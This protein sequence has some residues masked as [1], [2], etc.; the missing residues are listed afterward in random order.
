M[1][2]ILEYRLVVLDCNANMVE[3]PVMGSGMH[4]E[5]LDD[6]ARK[7]RYEYSGIDD[8]VSKNNAIFANAGNGYLIVH[9]PE[10]LTLDQL[11]QLD[12]IQNWLEE[13]KMLEA[14]KYTS[15]KREYYQYF[16]NVAEN[17]SK[18]IIQSYY[19]RKSKSK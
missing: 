10:K 13:V 12:Y 14:C 15:E 1:K 6:F 8:L 11:Y 19:S 9:L 2:N 18:E 5:C 7:M 16:E 17:F 4:K 3:Y